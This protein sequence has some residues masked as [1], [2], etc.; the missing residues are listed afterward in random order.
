[1]L[2]VTGALV[3][4]VG[5]DGDIPD[6]NLHSD[7]FIHSTNKSTV[8]DRML[9]EGDTGMNKTSLLDIKV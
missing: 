5:Y 6:Q 3:T 1:M 4:I 9:E 8:C 2:F 7:S